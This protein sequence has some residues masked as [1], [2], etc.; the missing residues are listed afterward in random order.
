M[1]KKPTLKP[2]PFKGCTHLGV[3]IYFPGESYPW[4]V[5]CPT[6]NAFGPKAATK[7]W[8]TRKW[9]N[10]KRNRS[11]PKETWQEGERRR[12]ADLRF[13]EKL[14]DDKYART[15]CYSRFTPAERNNF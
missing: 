14:I 11:K 9:N 4:A 10:R 3:A 5:Y 8:A 15:Q 13:E 1:S 2:C 6:C 7:A 12:A